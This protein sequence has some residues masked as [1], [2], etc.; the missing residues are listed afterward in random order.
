MKNN[1]LFRIAG[2]CILVVALLMVVIHVVPSGAPSIIM[3]ILSI[4]I[5]LGLIFFF[6][7]LYVV[8]RPES[9]RLS[10][11]GLVLG[12]IAVGLNLISLVSKLS[13]FLMNI[14]LL[15]WPLPFLVFG[16]LAWRSKRMPRG[17]ALVGLLTGITFLIDGVAGLMGSDAVVN[18]VS[19]VGDIF[20]LVW[21]VWLGI[22]FLSKKF[23]SAS[24]KPV[25]AQ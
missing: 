2:W 20:A 1:Q 15:L 8:H 17:L 24:P 12:I 5:L 11:A 13:A 22:V 7:M 10:L 6:Y 19:L 25:A 4:A 23:T 16:F 21:L 18:V 9:A 14:G 3:L